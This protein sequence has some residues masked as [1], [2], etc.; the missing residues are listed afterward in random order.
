MNA[1]KP[2]KTKNPSCRL[3][4]LL[5]IGFFVFCEEVHQAAFLQL[6]ALSWR[7]IRKD[8]RIVRPVW[9]TW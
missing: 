4:V 5:T 9:L 8:V 7:A 1:D 2:Q 6:F 3:S